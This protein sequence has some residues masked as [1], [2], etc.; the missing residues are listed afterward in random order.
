M[1]EDGPR[2]GRR[3]EGAARDVVTFPCEYC[4]KNLATLAGWRRHI[5]RMHRVVA[6]EANAPVGPQTQVFSYP[7]FFTFQTLQRHQK[8]FHAG[9]AFISVF[10]CSRCDLEYDTARRAANHFQIHRKEDRVRPSVAS[11]AGP[12]GSQLPRRQLAEASA[13]SRQVPQVVIKDAPGPAVPAESYGSDDGAAG[14]R[15]VNMSGIGGSKRRSF[16]RSWS[17]FLGCPSGRQADLILESSRV[18]EPLVGVPLLEQRAVACSESPVLPITEGSP[19]GVIPRCDEETSRVLDRLVSAILEAPEGPAFEEACD[20]FL[21]VAGTGA[22]GGLSG[23]VERVGRADVAGGLEAASAAEVTAPPASVADRSRAPPP[24]RGAPPAPRPVSPPPGVDAGPSFPEYWVGQLRNA[25]LWEEFEKVCDSFAGALVDRCRPR[26]GGR[27]ADAPTRPSRPRPDRP[28]VAGA[29]RPGYDPQEASR[30]QKLYRHSRKRAFR[31]VLGKAEDRYSGGR[32][33]AEAFFSR[34]FSAKNVDPGVISREF[35]KYVSSTDEARAEGAALSAPVGQREISARLGRMSNSAPGPDRVEYQHLK[36]MDGAC[37]VTLEI[38][39]RCLLSLRIPAS[40]KQATTVL[41][42][43]KGDT[44]DPENFRPIALQSCLYKLFMAVLADRL[45]S[46]ALRHSMLSEAQKCSRPSEGCFE[47]SFLLNTI[48]KDARRNQKD[49]FVAWLDLRNAFGSVPHGAI[50][51]AL[52][53]MGASAQLIDLL[54]DVYTGAST[55][56]NTDDGPTSEV[57]ILSGVKQGCPIS[58][59]LFNLTIELIVRAVQASAAAGGHGIKIHGQPVS[60]LAYADDLVVLSRTREGL[61]TLLDVASINADSLQLKFK[62]S[63][64][65]SLSLFGRGGVRVGDVSFSIQGQTIPA[66][67]SEE[68]YRYLGTPIGVYR[69]DEDVCSLVT[70]M[71]ADVLKIRQSLLAPWQKLDAI[72]TFVQPCLSFALRAGETTKKQ[73]SRLVSAVVSAAKEICQLP[74]RASNNYI[75]AGRDVGGLGLQHPGSEA[76]IQTVVQTV[77]MLSSSD[78]S[79]RGIATQQLLSVVRRTIHSV[80]VE[81]DVDKFLSG[82]MEG[83][84]ANSGNSGQISTLWSRVRSA[85]RRLNVTVR[86]ALSGEPV[87]TLGHSRECSSKDVCSALREW[88]REK[89]T[90]R[91]LGLPDQGKVAAALKTDKFANGSS[92]I[93]SGSFM[94]FC[95]WRFVHRARLNCVPTNAVTHR[96]NPAAPQGCRRCCYPRETLAHIVDHCPPGMVPIRRRHNMIQSRLVKAIRHGDVYV[97]QHVPGD[98]SPRER[99]DI[100]VVE[101]NKITIVD[102]AVPFDNGPDALATCA[103][104]KR[105]KYEA[106]RK[107]LVAKGKDVQVLGF[108]VG[109]LG[110][111]FPGNEL[112]LNRLGI[113]RSYRKL[114]RRLCCIDAISGSRDI[115]IE[116]MSGHRQYVEV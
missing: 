75:F 22:G 92:W 93:R 55:T 16:R 25:V 9:T 7:L 97:D 115:Y 90:Q 3:G 35:S 43:K 94:R 79:L 112:A 14:P 46:W 99:P 8:R 32:E 36:R 4:G 21:Q 85:T 18:S 76:D 84:L 74:V 83:P 24:R 47:H 17:P 82:S 109:A 30:L 33:S 60:I 49:I 27:S 113:S 39:N 102:V 6:A 11:V 59:I 51:A 2:P 62:P 64:C 110:S 86:R 69:D 72:Q 5:A 73:V 65:A 103:A 1:E 10:R 101:G 66:L 53:T 78:L 26:R 77:R 106:L 15:I 111:W 56:F 54:R 116:H 105:E 104:A 98:P 57:P 58:P 87:V 44:G 107:A 68:H 37:R 89:F 42:H 48:M 71:M 80:P 61:S 38:F 91:L 70:N 108:I 34:V 12:S 50:F 67:R 23:S 96:W 29:P 45:R 100:T 63:K 13:D 20:S 88:T 95:D 41:I 81:S 114:M 28:D 40:W 31:V 19:V 52:D